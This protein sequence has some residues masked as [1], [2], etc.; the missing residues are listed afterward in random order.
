V[1][2]TSAAEVVDDEFAGVSMANTK[3]EI[4][5]AVVAAGYD[6]A[7]FEGLT[8]SELLAVLAADEEAGE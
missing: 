2:T 3:A 7:V 4:L 6:E 1:S 5:A 8:K